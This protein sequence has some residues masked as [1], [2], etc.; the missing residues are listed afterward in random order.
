MRLPPVSRPELYDPRLDSA[1]LPWWDGLPVAGTADPDADAR[2][3]NR[4]RVHTQQVAAQQ[5]EQA[6]ARKRAS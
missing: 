6:R 5:K 4:E 3:L 1:P 2:R